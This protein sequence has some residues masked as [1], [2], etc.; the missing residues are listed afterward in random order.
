MVA[1]KKRPMKPDPMGAAFVVVLEDLSSKFNVFGEALQGFRDEVTQQFE[2]IDRRF[3]Q[4]DRRFEQIDS[5]FE[6]IDSRFE[7]ADCRV[8]RLELAV[9]ENSRGIREIRGELGDV[10]ATVTRI[11]SALAAKVDRQEVEAIVERA[12]ARQR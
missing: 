9:L 8:G 1:R 5:R 4:V 10:R 6:Q 12:L 7:Q 2:Q 11:E 3:E